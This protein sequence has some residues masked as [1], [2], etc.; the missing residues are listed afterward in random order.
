MEDVADL[1]CT[2]I[3]LYMSSNDPNHHKYDFKFLNFL[4]C[5]GRVSHGLPIVYTETS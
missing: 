2:V 4:S 3:V 5:V 1:G